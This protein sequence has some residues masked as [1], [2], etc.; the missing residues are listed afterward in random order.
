MGM[1]WNWGSVLT[2]LDSMS[3]ILK[4][5]PAICRLGHWGSEESG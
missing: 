5:Y 3:D 2:G 1:G 4:A